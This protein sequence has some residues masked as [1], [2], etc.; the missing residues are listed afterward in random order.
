MT[1]TINGTDPRT[2]GLVT[3]EVRDAM[4][5]PSRAFPASSVLGRAGATRLTTRPDVGVRRLVAPGTIRGTSAADARAKYDSLANLFATETVTVIMADALDRELVCLCETFR[6]LPQAAQIIAR[7]LPV[8]IVLVAFDPYWRQTTDTSVALSAVAAACPLGTAPVRPVLTLS[9]AA[10]NPLYTLNHHNGTTIA[11]LGLTLTTV[12]G[13]SLVVDC[14]RM[15]ITLNGADRLDVL[16]SGDF[17]ELD[18]RTQGAYGASQWPT[19]TLSSGAATAA[20]RRRWR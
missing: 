19:L 8:E 18:V 20:Y 15:Q 13:D 16:T 5:D 17:L 2:L 12:A 14:D 6:V 4:G 1:W 7:D 9:G 3:A 11:T 10:T